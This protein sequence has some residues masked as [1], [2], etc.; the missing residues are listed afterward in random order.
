M[1]EKLMQNV[2]IPLSIIGIPVSVIGIA[3]GGQDKFKIEHG[4]NAFLDYET[5]N[6]VFFGGL[7]LA[8]VSVL[9]LFVAAHRKN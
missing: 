7:A 3:V 8:L 9:A 2:V 6:T 4:Q 1:S 5:A